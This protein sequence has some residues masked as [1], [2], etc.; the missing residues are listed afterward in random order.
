MWRAF[1]YAVGIM[2]VVLG[3]ECLVIDSAVLHNGNSE[4]MVQNNN[5]WTGTTGL[6][7]NRVIK[8]A[9]WQPWSFL[10]SGSIVLLYSLTIK[11]GDH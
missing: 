2:L 1:F 8:P 3:V 10:A 5:I 11:K 4:E 6:E 9:E 7:G